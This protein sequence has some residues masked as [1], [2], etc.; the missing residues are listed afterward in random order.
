MSEPLRVAMPRR[1]SFLGPDDIAASI[2]S[3]SSLQYGRRFS[4]DIAEE[5]FA[6]MSGAMV[7]MIAEDLA[8]TVVSHNAEEI[9]RAIR[10]YLTDKAWCEPIL[11]EAIRDSVREWINRQM[12][13]TAIGR[14]MQADVGGEG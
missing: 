3:P 7:Q 2:S 13:S 10:S 9:R 12:N 11:K 1:H 8:K 14:M 4:L 6:E 5:A